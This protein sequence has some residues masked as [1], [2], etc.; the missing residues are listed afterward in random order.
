MK[1]FTS[2]TGGRFTYVDDFL[3]LQEL[4]LAF[5]EVFSECDNFIVSGCEVSGNSIS[6]G[7]VYLNGKLRVVEETPSITGGW[8]QYIYE[9]NENKN[10]PYASGGEKIGREVWGAK[11]GK[12]V[13]TTLT[14]LTGAVPK[15]IQINATGGLRMKDAWFGKYA[16]LLNPAA[17]SQAVKGIVNFQS[18]NA[19]GT[20][21]SNSQYTLRTPGGVGSVYF[22]GTNMIYEGLFS[23][24][25]RIQMVFEHA[26][27]SVKFIINGTSVATIKNTGILFT[28]PLTLSRINVGNVCLTSSNIYNASTTGDSGEINI[29]M[30][31]HAGGTSYFR[32]TNIGDGKGH[33]L[34]SISGKDKTLTANGQLIIDENIDVPIILRA[35]LTKAN[36]SLVQYVSW[37]D[38]NDVKIASCGFSHSD[39][40][41][42]SLVNHIGNIVITGE[43]TVDLGPAIKENG[44][45]LSEKYALQSNMTKE[46]NKK[47]NAANVYAKT[48]TYSSKQCD[49]KFATKTGGFSQFIVGSN[50]DEILCGQIGAVRKSDLTDFAQKSKLLADMA[51]TDA[52][53]AQIRK[54]IGAASAEEIQKDSLWIQIANSPNLYIRQIGNIVSIQG[55]ITTMH[56]GTA[57]RIPNNIDPPRYAV[58]YDAAMPDGCYWSCQIKGLSKECTVQRCNHHGLT[59][60]IS[61]TYMT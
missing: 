43:N 15:A 22:S 56:S 51:T 14:D 25:K 23:N 1:E 33:A 48:D 50:T 40:M 39:N 55:A 31:G 49:D 59:I 47:A 42:F 38:V 8:P 44:I 60:P 18:I 52:I 9:V 41:N 46:L 34:L 57:F 5:G 26:S 27:N 19:T 32:N 4:A 11:V 2:Q 28:Q 24:A 10:V 61:I 20:I 53:K 21:N 29:N 58:G 6:A 17:S 45:L 7:I 35:T 30:L 12:T 54:N 3:N 36:T 13:P 16:L 37:Q